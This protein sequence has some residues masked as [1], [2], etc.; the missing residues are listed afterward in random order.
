MEKG[1]MIDETGSDRSILEALLD[2]PQADREL[3]RIAVAR[4]IAEHGWSRE[5]ADRIYGLT[6]S[7]S[8]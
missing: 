8:S 7:C 5:D 2:N 1:E 3:S 4:A 6:G